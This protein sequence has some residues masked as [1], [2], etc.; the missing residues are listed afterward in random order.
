[1]A[2]A[3]RER[4]G[5]RTDLHRRPDVESVRQHHPRGRAARPAEL[6][7]GEVVWASIVNGIEN[8]AA[9]GKARPVVLVEPSGWAWRTIGLTTRPY[10]RD[11]A[12]RVAI[13]NPHAVGLKYPGWLWSGKLCFTSG[14]DIQDHIG[15]IDMPLAF[16]VIKLAGLTG[17]T[18]RELLAAARVH[19]GAT[20]GADLSLIEG[21]SA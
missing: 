18:I 19:H 20:G 17:P 7:S 1:M 13:P 12:P 6:A 5:A 4:P 14:I 9:S 16:E 3:A 2:P 15:W 11:G 21:G 8:P 10:H